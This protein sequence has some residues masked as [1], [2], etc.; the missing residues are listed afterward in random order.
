MRKWYEKYREQGLIVIGV[1]APEFSHERDIANVKQAIKDLKIP[2]AVALDNDFANWRAF[3]VW[4]WPSMFILD[5]QGVI[6]FTHV[7]E[8]AYAESERVIVSLLN[9]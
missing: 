2:Y 4:A 1:H 6:R 8:G 5:K 9:E 7:G 3:R